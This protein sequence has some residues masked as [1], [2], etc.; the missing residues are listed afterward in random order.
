VGRD[1]GIHCGTEADAMH[2]ESTIG[3][4]ILRLLG[5]VRTQT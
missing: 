4:V 1:A 5:G 3:K 2:A